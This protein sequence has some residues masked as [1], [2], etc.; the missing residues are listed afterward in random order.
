MEKYSEMTDEELLREYKKE[1]D[2]Y[3]LNIIFTRYSDVGYRT[4]L[5][6]MR[7]PSDAEDVLQ[8]GFIQFLQNVHTF[9]EGTETVKPWLMKMIVNASICK[10]REEKQRTHRQQKV[11][12]QRNATYEQ[13]QDQSDTTQDKEDLKKKILSCVDS[14]PDKYRSPICLVLYEGFSYPEVASVLDLPEKTV[15][16]QVS[17]GLEKLRS[18]LGTFGSALSITMITE[19]I[20]ESDLVAAPPSVKTMID[21]KSLYHESNFQAN[22]SSPTKA[23]AS[24][25]K[26]QVL[27]SAIAFL[28]IA[29]FVYVKFLSKNFG[30]NIKNEKIHL[31]LNFNKPM[32]KIPYQYMGQFKYLENGGLQKSGSIEILTN[33][34]LR[35]PIKK[36]ELPL[37]ISFRWNVKTVTAANRG[38]PLLICWEKWDRI[39]RFYNLGKGINYVDEIVNEY[40]IDNDEDWPKEVVWVTENS[41]DYWIND[42]RNDVDILNGPNNS[43]DLFIRLP[44]N[45]KIEDLL[46]ETV[47]LSQIPDV[48]KLVSINETIYKTTTQKETALDKHLLEEGSPARKPMHKK[49]ESS[50]NKKFDEIIKLFNSPEHD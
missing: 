14:L 34:I 3:F 30:F 38:D 8:L 9:R 2:P 32:E 4:A 28:V 35:L 46:I 6:Y 10:L 1:R 29:S 5:R 24:S 45:I 31:F 40:L 27:A 12:S 43:S 11:A 49:I 26:L 21:S 33:L 22:S 36:E 25:F 20:S 7:N 18:L 23:Y 19:L 47:G 16:T 17:R 15:R 41:V 13:N 50:A 42:Q 39:G 37:K 44:G 48:S